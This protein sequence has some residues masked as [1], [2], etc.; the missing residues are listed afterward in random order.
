MR[1]TTPRMLRRAGARE[2]GPAAGTA[3]PRRPHARAVNG[4]HQRPIVV[5]GGSAGAI[6][7]LREITASLPASLEAAVCV[8]IHLPDDS[9]SSLA[10]MLGRGSVL[11][12]VFAVNDAP[13]TE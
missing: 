12:V 11:P 3:P 6:E 7:P 9:R 10:T 4:S 13:L 1:A 8:V 2:R 5:I